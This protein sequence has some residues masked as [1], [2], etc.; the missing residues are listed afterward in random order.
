MKLNNFLFGGKSKRL[1]GVATTDE[2][3][4]SMDSYYTKQSNYRG[5]L[6]DMVYSKKPRFTLYACDEPEFLKCREE[7][8]NIDGKGDTCLDV[9]ERVCPPNTRGSAKYT[10]S[11]KGPRTFDIMGVDNFPERTEIDMDGRVITSRGYPKSIERGEPG[12]TGYKKSMTNSEIAR[13]QYAE[14]KA[15][16]G[17]LPPVMA[18]KKFNKT[19]CTKLNKNKGEP[20]CCEEDPNCKWI[21]TVGCV[22]KADAKKENV[23]L[24]IEKSLEEISSDG[25]E[26]EIS[27]DVESQEDEDLQ[28]KC[29]ALALL[30]KSVLNNIKNK[31]LIPSLKHE[32]T[33]Y[34][35]CFSV[36]DGDKL[37]LYIWDEKT[38]KANNLGEI[39]IL[40]KD[41]ID[42]EEIRKNIELLE[43]LIKENKDIVEFKLVKKGGM[44]YWDN[45]SNLNIDNLSDT[46]SIESNVFILEGGNIF[47]NE[48]TA[49]GVVD[50]GNVYFI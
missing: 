45:A 18:K 1:M 3:R 30:D 49:V 42:I 20:C 26:D 39:V 44:N 41:I 31:D 10:R 37:F 25:E 34:I 24:A 46:S 40:N 35:I 13:L 6:L 21:K 15:K 9:A 27:N 38:E 8:P 50:N 32:S 47:N 7:N 14:R 36:E 2:A 11:K 16:P 28:S 19:K 48:G 5:K 12:E 23:R 29:E 17:F 33:I 22:D 43:D 4:S